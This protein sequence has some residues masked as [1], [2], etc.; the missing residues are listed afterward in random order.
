MNLYHSQS[1]EPAVSVVML[2]YNGSLYLRESLESILAQTFTNFELLI[3]NDGSTDDSLDIINS[4]G[5]SRIRVISNKTNFGVSASRNIGLENARGDFIAIMDCDDISL[6]HRLQTQMKFM[7]DNPQIGVS[8]SWVSTIGDQGN[9]LWRYPTNPE[10]LR[11]EL[12]FHNTIAN[13][14]VIMRRNIL[15]NSRIRYKSLSYAEDYDLWVQLAQQTLLANIPCALVNYRVHSSQL[16][17]QANNAH[18]LCEKMIYLNQ[19]CEL[20]IHPTAQE[21]EVHMLIG[22]NCLGQ[23]KD[24][25]KQAGAWLQ[26]LKTANDV[27][28][29]YPEPAFTQV[30]SRYWRII[31]GEWF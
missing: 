16:S 15:L 21:L 29:C 1:I 27:R 3:I 14:S 4:C 30:L 23:N 25:C 7:E 31:C 2:V 24:F 8:G 28:K 17:S 6:P 9:Q 18:T 26:K 22:K 13:S 12:L 20:G 5:D 19:L 10:E 11:C